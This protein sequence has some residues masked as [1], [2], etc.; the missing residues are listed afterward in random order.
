MFSPLPRTA[1]KLDWLE[2][3]ERVIPLF[4]FFLKITHP[5]DE[6]IIIFVGVLLVCFASFARRFSFSSSIRRWHHRKPESGKPL[7]PLS[8]SPD[9]LFNVWNREFIGPEVDHRVSLKLPFS[10]RSCL[11]VRGGRGQPAR[12]IFASLVD[13]FVQSHPPVLSP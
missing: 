10:A 3:F 2:I 8:F 13:P 12:K 9:Y 11:V 4:F 7:S 5:R 6:R 1:K